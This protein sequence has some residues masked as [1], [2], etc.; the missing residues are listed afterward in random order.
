MEEVIV[1]IAFAFG[2]GHMLHCDRVEILSTNLSKLPSI[3]TGIAAAFGHGQ[4]ESFAAK[5]PPKG[6]SLSWKLESARFQYAT[7]M[8][9]IPSVW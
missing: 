5:L 4:L 9:S 3:V 2:H 8:G 7:D 6:I 1:T